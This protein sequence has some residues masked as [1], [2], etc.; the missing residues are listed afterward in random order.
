MTIAQLALAIAGMATG[1]ILLAL[2]GIWRINRIPTR[3]P[4]A[5]PCCPSRQPI[6]AQHAVKTSQDPLVRQAREYV[7]H[8]EW[9][10]GESEQV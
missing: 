10:T 7:R 3:H 4:A 2:V 9:E 1:A 8:R 6:T 5:P